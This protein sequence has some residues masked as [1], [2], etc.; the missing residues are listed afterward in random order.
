MGS[1][2]GD[3][4]DGFADEFDVPTRHGGYAALVADPDVDVV[5][6]PPRTRGTARTRSGARAGKH[7]LVEKP[8]TLNA[9][10]AAEVVAAARQRDCS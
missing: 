7:V 8:F 9:A 6:V 3:T 10:E 1:R 5:Y 4:A 2:R